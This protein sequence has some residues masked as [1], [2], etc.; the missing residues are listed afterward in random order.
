M[1][2]SEEEAE[3]EMATLMH[4]LDGP[5]KLVG[6]EHQY[7]E[8]IFHVLRANE[9]RYLAREDYMEFVQTD[10][11]HTMRGILV[12]WL[13]ELAEEYKMKQATLFLT[14]NYIDRLLSSHAV[15]R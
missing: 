5:Q 7:K 15:N 4:T 8:D 1:L 6:P 3:A 10:I 9:L 14:I 2:D 12:D 11:N 13:V